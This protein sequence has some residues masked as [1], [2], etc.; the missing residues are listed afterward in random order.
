M[1]T[2]TRG[3]KNKEG[4]INDNVNSNENSYLRVDLGQFALIKSDRPVDSSFQHEL[5]NLNGTI[6]SEVLAPAS[7]R[8]NKDYE[9]KFISML[10]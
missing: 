7:N 5:Q 3:N 1:V 2:K 4:F 9:C 6:N 8:S 10:G